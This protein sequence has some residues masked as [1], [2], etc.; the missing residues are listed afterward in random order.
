M[1]GRE[2]KGWI[3]WEGGECPVGPHVEVEVRFRDAAEIAGFSAGFWAGNG[4]GGS[5]PDY[6][7]HEGD[8]ESDIIAY[9]IV[10][11]GK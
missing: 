7:Q 11:D 1:T 6:W 4:G 3:P 8:D 10:G 9:R 5:D 2:E